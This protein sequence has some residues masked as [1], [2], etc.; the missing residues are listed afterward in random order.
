MDLF[1][2]ETLEDI[3]ALSLVQLLL[4]NSL[5]LKVLQVANPLTLIANVILESV[6]KLLS[7]FF[8]SLHQK[9]LGVD[10]HS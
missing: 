6:V 2:R 5:F 4:F 1:L 9:P 10:V 3:G 8:L 7:S